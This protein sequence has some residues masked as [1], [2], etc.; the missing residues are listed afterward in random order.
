MVG[1]ELY[2]QLGQDSSVFVFCPSRF[3][4]EGKYRANNFAMKAL[5][6]RNGFD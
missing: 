6:Y 1:L 3:Y 2:S 5:E 4:S